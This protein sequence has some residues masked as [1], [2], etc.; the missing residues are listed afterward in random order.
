[1]AKEITKISKE[2]FS[3]AVDYAYTLN[4][5]MDV[6][7]WAQSILLPLGSLLF[8]AHCLIFALGLTYAATEENNA[9]L[10]IFDTLRFIPDYCHSLWAQFGKITD[11]PF[12]KVA[13][14]FVLLYLVP[15]AAC[16]IVS[17][18]LPIFAKGQA[19]EIDGTAPKMAKQLYRYVEQGP[20]PKKD[21]DDAR[22]LWCAISGISTIAIITVIIAHSLFTNMEINH[23]NY[24]SAI[25]M[26]VIVLLGFV[27]V[28]IVYWRM[29]FVLTLLIKGFYTAP[30]DREAFLAEL[31]RY[32][33]SIDSGERLRVYKEEE[34]KK[35]SYDGWKYKNLGKTNHY[36]EKFN[37]HYATYMGYPPKNDDDDV[38][39]LVKDVEED[40]SGGGWGNY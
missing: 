2:N 9:H 37:E 31:K 7:R 18:F 6:I 8:A 15:V 3:A 17:L 14:F 16:G 5:K 39:R 40:L 23:S 4:K 11:L 22:S 28:Y 10:A 36:K 34:R 35:S 13:M 32:W 21:S 1:M 26:A 12:L 20:F 38:T 33:L 25:L 24:G 19:P 30:K 27:L 29:H